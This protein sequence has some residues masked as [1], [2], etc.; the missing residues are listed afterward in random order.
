MMDDGA[1]ESVDNSSLAILLFQTTTAV[2]KALIHFQHFVQYHRKLILCNLLKMLGSFSL[3][4]QQSLILYS[5]LKYWF[6]ASQSNFNRASYY[7]NNAATAE[8]DTI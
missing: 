2:T 1:C 7:K 6:P 8:I 4:I 3:S 5:S